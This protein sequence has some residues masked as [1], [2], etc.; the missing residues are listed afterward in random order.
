MRSACL[1]KRQNGVVCKKNIVRLIPLCCALYLY[2][3]TVCIINNNITCAIFIHMYIWLIL[4]QLHFEFSFSSVSSSLF[5]YSF[6]YF[7]RNAPKKCIYRMLSG[8]WKWIGKSIDYQH[9]NRN[10]RRKKKVVC[11]DVRITEWVCSHCVLLIFLRI[12]LIEL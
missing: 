12:E 5:L 6:T 2:T 4:I 1:L 8:V 11:I 9:C 7:S 3:L 10:T